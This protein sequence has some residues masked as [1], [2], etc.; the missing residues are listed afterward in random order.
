MKRNRVKQW[1]ILFFFLCCF[2]ISFAEETK[3]EMIFSQENMKEQQQ[4]KLDL[5]LANRGD[6]LS[7]GIATRYIDGILEYRDSVGAFE[8]LSE[9]KRIHGIGEATYRKLS[10]KMELRTKKARNPLY[11]NKANAKILSYYGF[12]KKEIKRIENF[13]LQQ[14][15]IGNNLELKKLIHKQQYEKYKDLFRYE[16]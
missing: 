5:N 1:L 7:A 2:Q 14:G 9:L 4:G 8:E 6:F 3:I 16:Q 10:K 12:S 13:R 11:I 15:R